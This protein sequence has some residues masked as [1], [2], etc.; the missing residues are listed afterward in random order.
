MK[1][2]CILADNGAAV[3]DD[4]AVVIAAV[5]AVE[6]V[7]E[8]QGWSKCIYGFRSPKNKLID[9]NQKTFFVC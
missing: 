3:V 1:S 7:F 9:A 8:I 2:S 6:A 5:V 4:V